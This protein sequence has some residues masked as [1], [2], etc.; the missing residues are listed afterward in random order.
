M[1][2]LEICKQKEIIQP[3]YNKGYIVLFVSRS[4]S[5]RSKILDSCRCSAFSKT[6]YRRQFRNPDNGLL[7][8]IYLA[9]IWINISFWE[10]A[11]LPLP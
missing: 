5:R 9:T 6:S 11:H 7:S 2:D 3:S 8:A 4:N 10:T 1:T